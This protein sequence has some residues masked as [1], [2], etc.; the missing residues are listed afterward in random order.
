[1]NFA[2]FMMNYEGER[3]FRRLGKGNNIDNRERYQYQ[4]G[5]EFTRKG[6]RLMLRAY[7][8]VAG[9]VP[10]FQVMLPYGGPGYLWMKPLSLQNAIPQ[11]VPIDWMVWKIKNKKDREEYMKNGG[12]KD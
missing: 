11:I 3:Y 1:M 4:T 8:A 2:N 9:K 7:R 5:V 6:Y 10:L 12:F